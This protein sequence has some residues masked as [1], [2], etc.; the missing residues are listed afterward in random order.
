MSVLDTHGKELWIGPSVIWRVGATDK[1]DD[2]V[3][4]K[5]RKSEKQSVKVCDVVANVIQWANRRPGKTV[6]NH[7][8]SWHYYPRL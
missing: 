1:F 5:V 6:V 2:D 8:H 7:G 3:I 4:K